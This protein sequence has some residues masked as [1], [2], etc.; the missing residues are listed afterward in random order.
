MIN[1]LDETIAAL[2][3]A[4]KLPSDVEFVST[5]D[6]S[7]TWEQFTTVAKDIEYNNGLLTVAKYLDII[8]VFLI[9]QK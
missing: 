6:G 7:L 8:V 3:R 4:K 1:L 9:L 5:S 2:I